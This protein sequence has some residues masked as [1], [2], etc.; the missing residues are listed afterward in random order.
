[1]Y[2][3]S[4]IRNEVKRDLNNYIYIKISKDFD[5]ELRLIRILDIEDLKILF[6]SNIK[7]D[8]GSF[9]K[10]L[11][12]AVN[13]DLTYIDKNNILKTIIDLNKISQE[14]F[15]NILTNFNNNIMGDLFTDE[16]N[17]FIICIKKKIK[18]I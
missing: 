12:D 11:S 4:I 2:N 10:E 6:N 16:I 13:D 8:E 3:F 7:H 17:L 9:E 15:S 5:N 1:M 14:S 18:N